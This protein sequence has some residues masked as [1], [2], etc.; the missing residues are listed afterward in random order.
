MRFYEFADPAPQLTAL[1]AVTDQLKQDLENNKADPEM[2]LDQFVDYL[3]KYDINLDVTDL[4]DMIK[5]PPLSDLIDNIQGDKIVFKGF[6]T[7]EAP[8]E[9]ESDKIVKSMAARART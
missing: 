7:P 1:N 3:Q 6:S 8:P 4:Y 2:N 5:N 9:E